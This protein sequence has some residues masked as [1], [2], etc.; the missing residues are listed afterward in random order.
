MDSIKNISTAQKVIFI[1]AALYWVC[2][3]LVIGPLD[4]AVVVLLSGVAET[5]LGCVRA[6]IS[7]SGPKGF[8]E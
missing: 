4:D 8:I 2:P 7:H 5:V 1:V 6:G 3:D